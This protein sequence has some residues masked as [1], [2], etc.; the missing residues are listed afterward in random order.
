MKRASFQ[1]G[2]TEAPDLHAGHIELTT[3]AEAQRGDR[4]FTPRRELGHFGRRRKNTDSPMGHIERGT[5]LISM[6][7]NLIVEW[8]STTMRDLQI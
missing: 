3:Y 2:G 5:R 7:G 4:E 1:Q 8:L 6:Q